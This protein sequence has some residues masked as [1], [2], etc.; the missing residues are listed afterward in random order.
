MYKLKKS[1]KKWR[2][3]W[4]LHRHTKS[5]H[6]SLLE[7]TT[8]MLKHKERYESIE[9][10]KHSSDPIVTQGWDLKNR[11]ADSFQ[12][13]YR[14]LKQVRILIQVPDFAFSPAGNSLFSN[15]LEA[16]SHLGV[17]CK[18]LAWNETVHNHLESFRPTVFL[19]SDQSEYLAKIDWQAINN[20]RISKPLVIGL[21]ASLA[22]YGNSPLNERLALSKSR[23]IDFFY[24]FRD[25]QYVNSRSE[26]RPFFEQKFPILFVPFAANI[27]HYYPLANV[28]RDL[29]YVLLA[30]RKREHDDYLWPLAHH[31]Q[32]FL[33]GPGWLHTQGF[34]FNPDRDR[35]FYARAKIGLNI[36]LPEQLQWSCE[37]NE[38][39]YQLA[40][41]GVPQLIDH[42][43]LLDSI[44]PQSSLFVANSPKEF[45][46][47][48]NYILANPHEAQKRALLA[49]KIVFERHTWLHR[50]NDLIRQLSGLQRLGV[51][52]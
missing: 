47:A 51:E 42:P 22:E 16:L 12:G 19:S 23:A 28:P 41:C 29:N 52:N 48:F 2:L 21:T 10:I 17:P 9:A 27:S 30:T 49:Q 4:G 6:Q 14:D 11:I 24:S 37:L 26:Y 45:N 31:H 44:F 43:K 25:R 38:R 13:L 3:R 15:L 39:T 5:S 7:E 40:A 18:A 36:H 32:G 20:Y 46:E 35:Y 1:I 33:D 34:S 50:A 8:L